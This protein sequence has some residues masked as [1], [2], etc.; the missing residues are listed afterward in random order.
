MDID[1][2][3]GPAVADIDEPAGEP[4]FLLVITHGAGGGVDAPDLLAVRD[5]AVA[6]GGAVARVTQAFRVA[7]RRSPGAGAKAQDEAWCAVVRRLRAEERFAAVPL[8]L[9]GRSNGARVACRT[10][11]A[12]GAA[13]VVALAF[14]LQGQGKS[15]V[16]RVGE[17]RG[18]GVPVLVVNG[19]RD[20]FG[21]PEPEAGIAVVVRPG[22]RHDL[23]KDPRGVA[24]AV[25][26]WLTAM[27]GR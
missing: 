23:A 14:P 3:R 16:S 7:G 2:P 10:A 4:R 27:L 17:L 26:A 11:V 21:V 6:Q 20:P 25:A 19:D 9:G 15:A 24:E 1:T 22:E 5:A 13:A 18:A 8:V 12:L